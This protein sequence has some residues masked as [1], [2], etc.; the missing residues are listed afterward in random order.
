METKTIFN[1]IRSNLRTY[2][3][4]SIYCCT[5]TAST[6]YVGR[7]TA[8][9][10]FAFPKNWKMS[11][12]WTNKKLER[13]TIYVVYADAQTCWERRLSFHQQCKEWPRIWSILRME[14]LKCALDK[15]VTTHRWA[16][17]GK[18]FQALCNHWDRRC[19]RPL[20]LC[21]LD[22]SFVRTASLR[23]QCPVDVRGWPAKPLA[24]GNMPKWNIQHPWCTSQPKERRKWTPIDRGWSKW[25]L[26]R[27]APREGFGQ[28]Y[29]WVY[30][31]WETKRPKSRRWCCQWSWL[32]PVSNRIYVGKM[33]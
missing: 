26:W 32:V 12:K 17:R 4:W 24:K 30:R 20:E 18:I 1:N 22:Q 3:S 7:C 21:S 2:I 28:F 29:R 15:H 11:L 5:V 14:K 27:W 16:K 8:A 23:T 33:Y 9:A 13:L 6:G 31:E 25:S 10:R 19:S